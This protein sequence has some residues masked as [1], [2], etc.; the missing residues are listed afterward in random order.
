MVIEVVERSAAARLCVEG[1]GLSSGAFPISSVEVYAA[2]IRRAASLRCPVRP[3]ALLNE[4]EGLLADL[5]EER[6]DLKQRLRDILDALVGYG[7]LLE[8]NGRPER[9]IARELYL[10]PPGFT[11]RGGGG[12]LLIGVRPDSV[13]LVGE[14]LSRYVEYR[15]HTRR[16]GPRL[17]EDVAALLTDYGLVE[18]SE[19]WWLRAPRP[20]SAGACEAMYDAKLVAAG[21][22]DDVPGVRI[23][24]VSMPI[25]YYVGR[26]RVP[27]SRDNGRF[28]ARRPQEFGSDL[29]CYAAISGGRVEGLIDLPLDPDLGRGCDEAWRLAAAK[30]SL[31][32]HPQRLTLRPASGNERR[33][34]LEVQMPLPRWLQ[35]RWDLFGSQL[36]R[37]TRSSLIAYEMDAN[38]VNQEVTFAAQSL[39]LQV[40]EIPGARVRGDD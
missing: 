37:K 38:E 8:Y 34:V 10:A 3:L 28:V 16:I 23:L 39:W 20:G 4:V 26:W 5:V 35:R 29:W 6:A 21:G 32:G 22:C 9:T 18:I 12:C 24:D 14:G 19:D 40:D 1:L 7:D 17:G 2:A 36:E 25:D 11:K 15:G 31:A 27:G 30:D 33:M 13:P